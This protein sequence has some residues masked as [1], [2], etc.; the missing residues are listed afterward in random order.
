MTKPRIIITDCDHENI[1]IETNVFRNESF[2]FEHLDC[3]TEDDVIANCQGASV[4]LNQYAPITEKVMANLPDL[5]LVVRYGVGVN[6][7]DLEAADKYGVQVCN[8]PDYGTNEV[9][10]HA[11]AL[12]L[13]LTRKIP[14]MNQLVRSGDWDYQKSIPIYRHSEQTV[15]I[16][17]LG[18]IGTSFAQKVQALGCRIIVCDSK[19]KNNQSRK[20]P[21]GME[22]VELD[23]LLEQSD[24][25]SIHCPLESAYN[26]L[27]VDQL[28]RMKNT[29]YLV[30]VSRGG[31]VNESA[32]DTALEEGWIA[33]AA[34]DVAEKEP[35]SADSPLFKHD[36]FLCTPH[37]AWYSEQA[38]LELK[39]KVAEEAV[40]FLKGEP[41]HYPINEI[42]NLIKE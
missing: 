31:I 12:M 27:D 11:L 30:N 26:L 34:V 39:R 22:L 16:I 2:T 29:A 40:R 3:K 6:N 18:R 17:G 1:D 4:F 13:A 20:L 42:H 28:K 19:Y 23:E 35:L 36:H 41:V 7:V 25:V 15:G 32:L 38:A 33:G 10:D 8:V 5:K 9:A 37:M 21:D 14:H 24:V